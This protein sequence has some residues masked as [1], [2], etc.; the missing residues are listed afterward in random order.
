MVIHRRQS[1]DGRGIRCPSLRAPGRCA[2][3]QQT[4]RC[5]GRCHGDATD[6]SKEVAFR[7]SDVPNLRALEKTQSGDNMELHH[8]GFV[9]SPEMENSVNAQPLL[10]TVVLKRPRLYP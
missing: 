10:T 7:G 2:C 3:N 1:D 5:V 8:G 6:A 4:L 9:A